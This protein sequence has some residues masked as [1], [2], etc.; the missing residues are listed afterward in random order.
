MKILVTG[1]SGLIGRALC[2]HLEEKG[3][4]V[5]RVVRQ[6][7]QVKDRNHL[8]W[9]PRSENGL[10]LKGHLETEAVI[11]LAGESI[12]PQLWT[13]EKKSR[14]LKSRVQGTENLI[15]SFKAA[16][17][18]PK[19][20]VSASAIGYYGSSMDEKTED[21]DLGPGFL[22]DVTAQWEKASKDLVSNLG[23]FGPCRLVH[24][25]I[26]LVLSREGGFLKP[27][28]I[29]FKLG[30]GGPVGSGEQWM[31]W[32]SR[33]DVVSALAFCLENQSVSGPVN[34]TGPEPVNNSEFTEIFGRVLSRPTRI[35]LPEFVVKTIFG[36]MGRETILASIRAMPKKLEEHGF[37]FKHRTLESALKS[38]LGKS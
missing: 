16:G 19:V 9:N 34:L 26:G 35:P 25:R 4:R 17:L 14:I 12:A 10:V 7:S 27:L 22:A 30:L 36:E 38:A 29:P 13:A 33:E 37:C 18:N 23:L 5:V 2:S 21:S 15:K 24:C 32:I 1:S 6:A 3:H 8:L 11:H 31:S 20:F 28:L